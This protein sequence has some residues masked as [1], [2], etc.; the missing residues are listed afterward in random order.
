MWI[1][2]IKDLQTKFER[3]ITNSIREEKGYILIFV[4]VFLLLGGLIITPLLSYATTMVRTERLVYEENMQRFYAADSGIEDALWRIKENHLP[5]WLRETWGDDTYDYGPYSYS[6]PQVNSKNI[7][8]DIEPIWPL[9][10]L[11]EECLGQNFPQGRTPHQDLVVVG[12]STTNGN[13][14]GTYEITINYDESI[15]PLRLLKIGAWIPNAVSYSDLSDPEA[16][17]LGLIPEVYDRRDGTAIVWSF[18]HPGIDYADLP[19]VA[20]KKVITFNYTPSLSLVDAFSWVRAQRSDVWMSWDADVK[21]YKMTSEAVNPDTGNTTTIEAYTS[22]NES[23]M[24]STT[25]AGDYTATG[26]TLMID[27][28]PDSSGPRRDTLLA[29]SDATVSNIPANALISKAYLYWSGWYDLTIFEDGCD[30]FDNFTNSGSWSISSSRFRGNHVGSDDTTRYLEL[31]SSLDLSQYAGNSVTL[32]WDQ[33]ENGYL[34]GS[35]RLKFKLS[36]DGGSTWSS[37]I[38]A[39]SDDIGDTPQAFSYTI[40]NQYLTASFKF[41]FYLEGFE[42]YDEYCYINNIELRAPTGVADPTCYFEIDGTRVYYDTNG[43]PQVDA[44]QNE[45]LTADYSQVINNLDYGNPHGYTYS[46]KKDVTD[47]V[48]T[49][50]TTGNAT[51]TVGG[52]DAHWDRHD[53]WAY[54]GWSLVIIYTNPN[55]LGHRLYLYDTFLY[56]DHQTNLDFDQDGQPGGTIGGFLVPSQISGEGSDAEAAK[57]TCF[58]TE[59]DD[60]YNGDYIA[61]NG[62]KLWD[63]TGAGSLN[64]V[65]NNKSL[66]LSADGVDIDTFSVT[67]G[68]NVLATGDTQAQIDIYTEIDIWNLVYIILSFR[69]ETTGTGVSIYNIL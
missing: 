58:V 40:P 3:Y 4:L 7:K 19:D 8:V 22:K 52:V 51:Y 2:F 59:G 20:G 25:I 65:W 49:F 15:G 35:D 24:L 11:G 9:E 55:T 29:E 23:R 12:H 36:G 56:C 66:G 1:V 28:Y 38:A 46:S 50:A 17:N 37:Y 32:S 41:S 47:L 62:T 67:W 14:N 33:S 48:R 64:D 53:E 44:Y 42:D 13:G 31:S 27:Q 26:N 45:E 30:D 18:N 21:V 5:G 63:G 57:I 60:Y 39:F 69:S 16:N 10:G 54:A 43:D 34:E 61:L 68:D 6:L